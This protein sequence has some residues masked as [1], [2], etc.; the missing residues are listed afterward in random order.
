MDISRPHES[1]EKSGGWLQAMRN[2]N[3]RTQAA[4]NGTDRKSI[5]DDTM[6]KD[7]AIMR[8]DLAEKGVEVSTLFSSPL[9]NE[10][11]LY[12]KPW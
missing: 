10:I 11:P 12:V 2:P 6:H 3:E 9:G 1:F 5:D 4:V 7:T 8:R